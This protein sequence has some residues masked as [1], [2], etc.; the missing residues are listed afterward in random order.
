LTFGKVVSANLRANGMRMIASAVLIPI[1]AQAMTKVLKKPVINPLN[2]A[3][4][5]TGLD[6][7]V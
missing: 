2:K 3:L 6:V 7:K 4:K 5:M 1:A